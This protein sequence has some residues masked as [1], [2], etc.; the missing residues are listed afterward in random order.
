MST[1][2]YTQHMSRTKMGGGLLGRGG[3]HEEE[4]QQSADDLG[5]PR[6]QLRRILSASQALC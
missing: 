2:R 1:G 5:F 3:I 4:I 6:H